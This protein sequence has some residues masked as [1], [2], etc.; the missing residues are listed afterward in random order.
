[1]TNGCPYSKL[2]KLLSENCPYKEAQNKN[3][4]KKI[5]LATALL[6]ATTTPVLAATEAEQSQNQESEARCEWEVSTS[7]GQT[8]KVTGSCD[9]KTQ[10]EQTQRVKVLGGCDEVIYRTTDGTPICVHEVVDAGL[11]QFALMAVAITAIT[12]AGLAALKISQKS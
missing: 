6:L 10:Q 7:Y 12:G 9:T 11:N 3:T 8:T 1:M 5:I 2:Q 4:M